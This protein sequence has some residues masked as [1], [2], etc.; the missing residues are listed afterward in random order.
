[1]FYARLFHQL[2]NN[3]CWIKLTHV[4]KNLQ[5]DICCGKGTAP[6]S[7]CELVPRS[8]ASRCRQS[9]RAQLERHALCYG[10]TMF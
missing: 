3:I 6:A 4:S 1:M 10:K 9:L 7:R 8:S 2:G 5:I